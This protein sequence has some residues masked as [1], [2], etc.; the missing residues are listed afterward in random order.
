MADIQRV[1]MTSIE[2]VLDEHKKTCKAALAVV[3]SKGMDYAREQHKSG[4]TLANISNSKNWGITDTVCQ[5][6]LVRLADKFS[7]L[8]SLTKD[9]TAVPV[10]QDEKVEDTIQD[11]INY[12]I[13]LKIK[14]KEERGT[15]KKPDEP[16]RT[17]ES[18]MA[19]MY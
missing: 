3:K 8:I 2:D 19:S 7:R 12:L 5:G 14:Y 18:F 6:L 9:P 10:V 17:K 1:G 15:I 11:M 16:P 13:Y 4:D